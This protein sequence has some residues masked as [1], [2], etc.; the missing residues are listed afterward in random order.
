M[1]VYENFIQSK[2]I[3]A[4]KSIIY[5]FTISTEVNFREIMS[6]QFLYTH[7][8]MIESPTEVENDKGS[9]KVLGLTLNSIGIKRAIKKSVA[10]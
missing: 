9:M 2:P 4:S 10:L 7:L 8:A 5:C 6:R 3:I 1:E